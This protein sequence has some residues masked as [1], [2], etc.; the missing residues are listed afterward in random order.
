M[1]GDAF[2]ALRRLFPH[3][4]IRLVCGA[5]NRGAAEASGWFDEIRTYDFFPA[6]GQDWTGQPHTD[7][8]DFDPA[9]AGRFDLAIDLRVDDDTR[10]LLTRVDAAL[11]CGIG[12]R[13]RFPF[14]DIALPGPNRMKPEPISRHGSYELAPDR[15]RSRMDLQTPLVHET[16]ARLRGSHLIYGPYLRLPAGRYRATFA[17]RLWGPLAWLWRRLNIDVVRDGAVV[18]ESRLRPADLARGGG[19]APILEFDHQPV[20]EDG[21]PGELEF[22][23]NANGLPFAPRLVFTGVRL[24]QIGALGPPRQAEPNLHIGEYFSLLVELIRLRISDLGGESRANAAVAGAAAPGAGRILIA[25]ISNS[26]L[27]DWPIEHYAQ[28]TAMLLDRTDC[29][30]TLL[31]TAAQK[32]RLDLIAGP[33]PHPRVQNLAGATAWKDLPALLAAADLVIC[34]N[35]GVAHLAA[36]LGAPTLAIYSGSHWP[37]EWGPRGPRVRTL[38]AKVPCSPCGHDKLSACPHTQA[39]MT[40]I[41]SQ[42]VLEQ[43]LDMIGTK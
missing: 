36:D 6:N 23:V 24:E 7:V 13:T 15:F 21:R 27:R 43:A 3:D 38:M 37:Q 1:G 30:I 5:W 25:P 34:N 19:A 18:I 35:S 32:D 9:A 10:H 20:T 12:T 39:C 40:A 17:L 2:E 11:R 4:Y 22:R 33:T 31:G 28:L 26:T 14:L 16:S 42:T 29:T 41:S 8:S